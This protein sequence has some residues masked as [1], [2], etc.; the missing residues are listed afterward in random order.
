MKNN[1]T[2]RFGDDHTKSDHVKHIMRTNELTRILMQGP[3]F[4]HFQFI[5]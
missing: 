4:P 5:N 3:L 1:I 2:H